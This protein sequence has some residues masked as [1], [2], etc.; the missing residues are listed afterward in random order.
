MPDR[1]YY[2]AYILWSAGGYYGSNDDGDYGAAHDL[3]V[4]DYS[5][6]NDASN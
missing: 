1:G 6:A 2:V 3:G 4:D 5:A